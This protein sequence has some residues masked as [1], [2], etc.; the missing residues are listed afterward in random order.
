MAEHPILF[1]GPM[2]RA[3]LGERKTQTRRLARMTAAGHVKE[4]RGHRRWHPADPGSAAACPF[5]APG[6]T[7]WVRETWYDDYALRDSEP[8]PTAPDNYI[9]Y[10]ADGEANTFLEDLEG[11]RW[12]PSIHMPR[13]ASRLTLR[14]TDARIE[15]L[16][17]ITEE[18][19][20]AEGVGDVL[21]AFPAMGHDQRLTS[22]DLAV[23]AP[24][25]AMFAILWD[26]INGDRALWK[27]N[28]RVWVVSF[29]RVSGAEG[30]VKR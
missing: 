2:V 29:E 14:V 24:H 11:F 1:S 15:R 13:W 22:G 17:D 23:E 10:R 18:D 25:R 28:P 12:R 6:A 26:E 20:K 8:K 7:L 3:I 19:A 30:E 9:F 16:Q 21:A 5:G 4:P 27:S